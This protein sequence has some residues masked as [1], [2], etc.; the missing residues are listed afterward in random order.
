MPTKPLEYLLNR[1]IVNQ[2]PKGA[3]DRKKNTA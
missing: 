2:V 1:D 3:F